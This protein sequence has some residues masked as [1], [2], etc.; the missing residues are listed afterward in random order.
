MTLGLAKSLLL[1]A[2]LA[3]ASA[4]ICSTE[5][6]P[7]DQA[8]TG[9]KIK[10]KEA[11]EL[12]EQMGRQSLGKHPMERDPVSVARSF[13]LDPAVAKRHI[14]KF[15]EA[16]HP[17]GSR[18]QRHV[19]DYLIDAAQQGGLQVST[20]EFVAETPNPL[21][22]TNAANS[23]RDPTTLED[24]ELKL[25][26]AKAGRNIIAYD[27]QL[28]KASCIV[29]LG[30]H[31]DTKIIPGVRYLGANDSGSSSA[32]ILEL[33]KYLRTV[34]SSNGSQCSLAAVWFDGEEAVLPGWQ[35]G[36]RLHPAQLQ[37]NTYG[38]RHLASRLQRCSSEE[39]GRYCL[40]LQG[41]G[42]TPVAALILLDM[43]GL[44]N[45][46]LTRD[47]H[48]TDS[49]LKLGLL[50]PEALKLPRNPWSSLQESKPIADDHLPFLQLGIPS[51]N[52]IDFQQLHT[53]HRPGDD[54][55]S[56]SYESM[57][58]VGK[59][60]LFIALQVAGSP[61]DFQPIAD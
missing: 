49:L 20:D 45:V 2:S 26:I 52:L 28:A 36:R 3:L 27:K 6:L 14:A 16:P 61:K 43:I 57:E 33:L 18:E 4:C 31:Y 13:R 25:T 48:S 21:L 59:I 9:Q 23:P 51:L 12:K 8:T 15:T 22:I 54:P 24:S 37:D 35:D 5:Q 30:S 53:W 60:A 58:M 34:R 29:L 10:F 50:A 56:L 7:K 40:S 41:V 19:G 32:L 38:S 47:S 11:Q 1:A 42:P 44:P 39:F 55:D 17:F 46:Q